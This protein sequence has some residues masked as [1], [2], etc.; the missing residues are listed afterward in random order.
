MKK[1]SFL[2]VLVAMIVALAVPSSA[3]ADV[4]SYT[5]GFQVQNL[6]DAGPASILITFYNQDGSQ[7]AQ[8]SDS[9]PAFD[10]TTYFPLDDV[11]PGF[12]GSVVISSDVEIAAIVNVLGNNGVY[13]ASYIGFSGGASLVNL[14]LVM[15]NNFGI[16]TWFNVQNT[17]A[18]ATDVTVAYAP[19]TCT[20]TATIEPNAAHRFDQSTNACLAAG[21]V[22]AATVDAGTGSVAVSVM[23]VTA[24]TSGLTPNLLA[25]NGFATASTAPVMPLVTSGYF[26]SGTGIQIQNTGAVDTDVTLTYTP[27]TGF[28]GAVC[29]ETKSIVAGASTTF[30]FPNLPAGCYTDGGAAGANA[31]VGSAAVTGNTGAVELVAIVNQV[32]TG[33]GSAAA[34]GAPDPAGATSNVTLPLIMDRNFNIFTGFSVAN[35]GTDTT[36]VECTFTGTT[37]TVSGDVEPGQALT[38]VQLN[39]IAAGYVGSAVCT[40]SGGT[41]NLIV[42]VVNELTAGAPVA[43]DALLVYEG[44]NY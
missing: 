42:A 37:Y 23:Q 16:S 12:D 22:G 7:A 24:S 10:S 18:T 30:G 11:D 2:F 15:K 19:G 41:D 3:L 26:K 36:T 25:Y 1:F 43:N 28:P 29:T 21:F 17:G 27:S 34:Y 35:V 44:I 4:T 40:A 32:T 8:V 39:E 14:P 31:F 9:I 20:E 6:S 5:S 38:A 33:A 13:G